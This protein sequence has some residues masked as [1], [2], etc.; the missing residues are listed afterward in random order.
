MAKHG[1]STGGPDELYLQLLKGEIS[2]KEY[3]A[4]VRQRVNRRLGVKPS[5]S[6]RAK[7]ASA[8]QA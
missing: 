8:S 3:A 1:A 5:R 4:T 6:G 7:R 2:P